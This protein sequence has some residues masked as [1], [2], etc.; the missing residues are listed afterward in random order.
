M[1]RITKVYTR[2]GDQ[3]KTGLADGCRIGKDNILIEAI[4]SVDELNAWIGYIA[5]DIDQDPDW[6]TL[7]QALQ[8]VQNELFNLGAQLAVPK[9]ARRSNTPAIHTADIERLENEIDDFNALLPTLKSFILPGGE[10][11]SAKLHIAR[12][13][14]RRAE[15]VLVALTRV[16]A[17]LV[18]NEIAYLNRLSD[19]L[20]VLARH[21]LYKKN[22]EELL[23]QQN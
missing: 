18:G 4:G 15:R 20:F 1:V 3:G 17:D 6:Q 10:A 21:V 8:R 12:T 22:C 2:Q 19:W 16:N 9:P 5:T 11:S 13:V 14:C 7:M 23:W